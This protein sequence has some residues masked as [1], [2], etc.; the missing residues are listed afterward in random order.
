MSEFVGKWPTAIPAR[1]CGC[2]YGTCER[3]LRN[4]RE[5]RDAEAVRRA[6]LEIDD[7]RSKATDADEW[8]ATRERER[9]AAIDRAAEATIKAGMLAPSRE[10]S[11]YVTQAAQARAEAIAWDNERRAQG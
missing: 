8:W 2:T 10:R 5:Q 1:P 3:C 6:V 11:E 7:Q 9:S 4:R